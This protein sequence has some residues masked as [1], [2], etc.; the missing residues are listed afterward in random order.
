MSREL[1][2]YLKDW[3]GKLNKR[4]SD[5]NHMLS[6]QKH[7]TD[8]TSVGF[9]LHLLFGPLFLYTNMFKGNPVC[10]KGIGSSSI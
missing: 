5:L 2:S 6:M 1:W 9:P 7:T 8:K 10:W 4:K 3:F